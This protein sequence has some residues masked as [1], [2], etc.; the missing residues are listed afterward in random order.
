MNDVTTIEQG[1]Q[2]PLS[3]FDEGALKGIV[4][5]NVTAGAPRASFLPTTMGEAMEVAKLM[6][7]GSFVPPHLRGKP[8]D[9]LAVVMQSAR[10]GMDPFA[11][12]NKTYF[13]ND[14]MAYESQLVNAVVNSANA[15][16]GR[17]SIAWEG[18]S[19]DLVCTVTGTIKGDPEPKVRRVPIKAI[20]T[21]N[22]PLWKQDPEQQLAY[23]A[24]RAWARLYAPEMLMG[25]Y[26][27]EEVGDITRIDGGELNAEPLSAKMLTEQAKPTLAEELD[28][29]IP[30]FDKKATGEVATD[31]ATG[32]TEVDE[33]TSREL[34]AQ[35]GQGGEPEQEQDEAPAEDDPKAKLIASLKRELPL[36]QSRQTVENWEKEWLK[37]RAIY[38]DDTA[39]EIDE[40]IQTNRKRVA[41][42]E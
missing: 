9:C 5:Q 15:L 17:L 12:G 2:S 3:K 24:T 11:V 26:T 20:T 28:D 36:C 21:R 16:D 32:M 40:L 19:N 42:A 13:V 27:P 22:S 34:D 31:P 39:A 6:A 41:E 35:T 25:V 4:S 38:D 37:H 10:W 18:E 14:R 30:D 23:Y 1:N 29:E 7:A 8:G 33:E